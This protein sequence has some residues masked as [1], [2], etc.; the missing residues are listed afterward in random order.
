M[1][2]PIAIVEAKRT[3]KDPI[4]GRKQAEEYADDIKS[5]T[6]KDVFIFLSNGYEIW[7]W[8]RA[9]YGPRLVKGFFAQKDL[10]RLR[11]QVEM[12]LGLEI[13][14]VDSRIVDRPKSIEITKRVIEHIQRGNRKALVVMATGTGKTRV[15]MSIIDVLLRTNRAQKVL[16]F[17]ADLLALNDIRQAGFRHA[18]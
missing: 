8:D 1:G 2:A 5:Q 12:G 18:S 15:A 3:S 10:E 17:C 11:F 7:F 4:M 13:F 14:E 9:R 16:V 6:G